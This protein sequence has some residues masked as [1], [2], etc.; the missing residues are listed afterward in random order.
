[1]EYKLSEYIEY[2][3]GLVA[4]TDI[5]SDTLIKGVSNSSRSTDAGFIFCAVKGAK[6]DGHAF[7]PDAISRGASAVILSDGIGR[8]A[9]G[10]TAFV[11]VSDPYFAWGCV[12]EKFFGFP[13]RGMNVHGITGTNG[14]TSSAFILKKLIEEGLSSK[15]GLV[16]TVRYDVCCGEAEEASRTTPES[17][18][19]QKLFRT[20][21]DNGCRHAVIEAS[22]HGLHQH[23]TGRTEFSSA[24]FTNLTGDHLDYHHT[25]EEYYQAKKLLFTSMLKKG[26]PAVINTDDKWGERLFG[27]LESLGIRPLALSEANPR[28]FCRIRNFT[29]SDTGT[30]VE[31]E[32]DGQKI[33]TRSRLIGEHNVYNLAGAAAVTYTLGIAIPKLEEILSLDLAAPGRLEPV[34]LKNGALAFVDYAHTDDALF[35]VLS[36]L[37]KLARGRII[38]VFG[39][40]GDRDRTK[41]PRMGAAASKF[42]DISIITSDNPRSEEPLAIISEIK[43][44]VEPGA[45]VIEIADR[46]SAI[47]EAVKTSCRS[48]IILVAGKGHENYQEINGRK[49]HFDDMEILGRYKTD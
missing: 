29:L 11:R 35:R 36:A 44:G 26:A 32:I 42:S 45:N 31:L 30:D 6:L 27:E 19:I 16:S 14:K 34:K 24:I 2:L 5:P 15:C 13:T 10:K 28:A 8:Y 43:A 21:L 1:M 40:G 41:R 49:I 7:I 9:N 33:A 18:E 37:R 25:M 23:R 17:F 3:G 48:D 12:C 47:E 4:E 46:A 38:T 39:C 22:S 20:M